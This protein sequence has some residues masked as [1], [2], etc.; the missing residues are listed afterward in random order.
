M[1]KEEKTKLELDLP[2]GKR[3]ITYDDFLEIL[4]SNDLDLKK[5]IFEWLRDKEYST[6]GNFLLS[7]FETEIEKTKKL[8][9]LEQLESYVKFH[10]DDNSF[11]RSLASALDYL[12]TDSWEIYH[13]KIIPHG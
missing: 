2:S 11:L 7:T 9:H 4:R 10:S 8:K 1:G 6:I 12:G 5:E 13:N 3:E